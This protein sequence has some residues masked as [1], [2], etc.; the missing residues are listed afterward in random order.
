MY[1]VKVGSIKADT[2]IKYR[3]D[4][5][6]VTDFSNKAIFKLL[7]KDEL[8]EAKKTSKKEES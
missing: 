7:I 4:V 2:G 6:A 1:I 8:I 5:I 3:G